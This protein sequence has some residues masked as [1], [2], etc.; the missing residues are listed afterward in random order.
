MVTMSY[1]RHEGPDAQHVASIN[2]PFQGR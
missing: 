2:A 1:G